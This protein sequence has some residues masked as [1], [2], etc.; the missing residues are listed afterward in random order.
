MHNFIN[1]TFDLK[2]ISDEK[3]CL[4][5]VYILNASEHL[6]TVKTK[7]FKTNNSDSIN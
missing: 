5:A 3:I 1:L 6:S 7:C 4:R 2:K